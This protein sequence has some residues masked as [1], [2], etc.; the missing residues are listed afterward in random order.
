MTNFHPDRIAALRNVTD[1]FAGPIADEATTLVDGGLAVETWLRDRTVKMVSKTALLRRA[2]RRLDGG[3]GGWTDRYPDIE[4]ISFVGVSS[5]PAP[6]VDFLHGLCT[7]TTADIELH[8]RPGTAEYLT[9]RL[10]DL[11]SIEDPGQ[12]VTL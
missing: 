9:T 10:P 11:L 6:E 12:E 8:L 3:D 2:T 7:A 1:A 5:I 4:R